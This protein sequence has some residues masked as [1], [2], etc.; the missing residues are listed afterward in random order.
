MEKGFVALVGAGPGELGLLTIR[1]KE[2]IEKADVVVFDRLVSREILDIIPNTAK[3]I[4]VGKKSNNHLV[5]QHKINEIL[6]EEA[7]KGNFVVRLKGGDPFLFGRGGEELELLVDNNIS[8]E[9]VP[10]ITSAISVPSFAGIP[11]TH[12]DFCSSVH[13][14]TGHQKKN[15]TLRINF[16]ALSETNGTLVF[17]MGVSSLN[18][19]MD[20]LI[21]ANMDKKTPA[22]IIEN[23]T[24]PNQRKITGTIENLYEKAIKN[25][26]KSPSIIVVGK[27]CGLLDKYNW[28]SK[29]KL[30]G[31][32]IVVTRPRMSGNVLSTKLRNLGAFVYD[33]PCIDIEEILD[34]KL[35]DIEINRINEYNWLVFTSKNGVKIFFDYLRKN[36]KDFRVL[37]NLK[38]AAIGSQTAK[39]LN[40]YGIIVDYIPDVYEGKY[41]GEGLSQIVGKNEKVL[42]LRALKGTQEI[43]N[44]LSENNIYYM[45][46]PIYDT[47]YVNENEKEIKQLIDED[48]IDYVTFTSAST[49]EGFINSMPNVDLSKVMGL[50]I[51]NQTATVAK[52]Y[53]IRHIISDEATIDS[54]ID[55]ILE[56]QHVRD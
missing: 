48:E 23:G 54:M 55:K 15:E 16:K 51:G 31:K 11:V 44:K 36:K 1:G 38:I 3:K 50:C 29:R 6:L 19:I 17:L 9:V 56:V 41:L 34:N 40:D 28:F 35:L 53:G 12:R 43:T 45:D 39:S 22:A 4:N 33:Y 42:L 8:F 25:K 32:K 52:K 21:N 46:I 27:V 10:G 20:G 5:L 24:L 18:E 30:F 14:I 7:L 13:I 26:I 47:L 49:V 37:S 2:L